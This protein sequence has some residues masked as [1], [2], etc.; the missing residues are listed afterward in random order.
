MKKVLLGT[1][2]IALAG[3]FATSANSAEW[4]VKVGG[5]HNQMVAFGTTDIQGSTADFDG[6]DVKQ[7]AEIFFLPSITL[8]NGLKF[9]ANVQLES[10]GATGT[11]DTI[12]ESYMFV[13]G[14]FGEINLGSENSAGYKMHYAAPNVAIISLNSPST[15]QYIAWGGQ[16]TGIFRGTIGGTY[17]ENNRNNDADRITYYTPRFAGFQVGASYARD[18]S[19]DSNAQAD[20]NA[21]GTTHDIFDLGANYVNDFGGVNLAL[22]AR[23]GIATIEPAA[24]NQ[25]GQD[26]TVLGF[27]ANVG[28]GGFT[29]GGSWAEQNDAGQLDGTAYDIGAKYSTGPW[30]FSLTYFHGE[31]TQGEQDTFGAGINYQ[32]AKGVRLNGFGA[33]V[34]YQAEPG[35][36]SDADGFVIG[37]GIGLSF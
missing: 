12:D 31:N 29:I 28:F 30:S 24:A 19:Q 22:S 37:T 14:S 7:N 26:P 2:A 20:I 27:G 32:L 17:L 33:Y 36:T 11:A 3:A 9:G 18:A 15:T 8:D 4:N 34:D 21:F 10:A 1:S 13:R 25:A 6:I 35:T 16:A 5:Y 23:W